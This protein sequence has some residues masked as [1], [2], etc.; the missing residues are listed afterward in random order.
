MPDTL[1]YA[2]PN[3]DPQFTY[4]V[5]IRARVNQDTCFGSSQWSDWSSTVSTHPHLFMSTEVKQ[6]VAVN[7]FNIPVV[8][9][10]SLGIP[11]ILL[12]VVLL[13][14]YQRSCFF[15]YD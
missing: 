2:K 12:A 9:S 10:I 3:A 14:R 8:L 11:M 6:P 15:L 7:D 13:V 5:R 4:R 1:S